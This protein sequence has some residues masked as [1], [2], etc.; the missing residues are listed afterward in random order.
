MISAETKLPRVDSFLLFDRTSRK[1]AGISSWRFSVS[2]NLR[3]LLHL[4]LFVSFPAFGSLSPLND[5]AFL[6]F[7]LFRCT[8]TSPWICLLSL[9]ALLAYFQPFCCVFS[10]L[11]FLSLQL[12]SCLSHLFSYSFCSPCPQSARPLRPAC[13][14]VAL[15]FLGLFSDCSSSASQVSLSFLA[16]H[17]QDNARAFHLHLT[18]L[19]S[20]IHAACQI[21]CSWIHTDL[22]LSGIVLDSS[23]YRYKSLE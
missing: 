12:V 7:R 23:I 4:E 2:R 8:F 1:S 13:F 21:P 11:S 14:C 10:K 3:S 5:A 9:F 20:L 22:H 16:Q 18:G 6:H 17:H 19:S 15:L